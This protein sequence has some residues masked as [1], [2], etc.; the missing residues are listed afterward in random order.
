[1]KAPAERI[2]PAHE[3]VSAA[4]NELERIAKS[5][6]DSDVD[7][8]HRRTRSARPVNDAVDEKISR[9][10]KIGIAAIRFLKPAVADPCRIIAHPEIFLQHLQQKVAAEIARRLAVCLWR[11][12]KSVPVPPSGQVGFAYGVIQPVEVA[13]KLQAL[14]AGQSA[15]THEIQ[16][17]DVELGQ[18]LVT[19]PSEAIDQVRQFRRIVHGKINGSRSLWHE[20]VHVSALRRRGTCVWFLTT[21]TL[22]VTLLLGKCPLGPILGVKM[23]SFFTRNERLPRNK[24]LRA[25][26]GK[27]RRFS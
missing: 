9:V 8:G 13:A 15:G 19:N 20:I 4:F 24:R 22:R 23:K 12:V 7:H 21:V 17:A 18:I 1:M 2:F 11:C 5:L 26:T 10:A 25:K 27:P 3:K 6:A 16:R 14:R